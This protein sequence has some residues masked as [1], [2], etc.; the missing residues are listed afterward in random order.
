M[1]GEIT[2]EVLQC[3]LTRRSIRKF[4]PEQI[5][6]IDLA[7]ILEAG[8]YAPSA[9][10]RQG[11]MFLVS[12]DREINRTLG[13][14]NKKAFTGRISTSTSYISRDQPSIADDLN[15]QSGFY[16]A[17]TVITL[18]G[19]ANFLYSES[20]CSVAA[21]NMLL[22]AHSLGIGTCMIGR[23]QLTFSSEYG[24]EIL[25]P[26]GIEGRFVA[27]FHVALGYSA[28]IHPGPKPRKTDRVFRIG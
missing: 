27:H 18:F 5:S 15:I 19:A 7:A 11:V 10:G 12:Q 26:A 6:E 2:N 24:K 14:I 3:I 4:K 22:A 8:M 9:G 25:E 21:E 17:P 16:E 13:I 20:D 23:A 28:A 1:M